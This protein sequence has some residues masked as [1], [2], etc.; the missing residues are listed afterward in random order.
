MVK[1]V[2][3]ARFEE[4]EAL[5]GNSKVVVIASEIFT[6]FGVAVSFSLRYTRTHR[7]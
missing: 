2:G 3:D 5:N 7:R 6:R 4:S 1:R